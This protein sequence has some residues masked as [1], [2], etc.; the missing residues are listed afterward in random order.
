MAIS[1]SSEDLLQCFSCLSARAVSLYPLSL[2]LLSFAWVLELTVVRFH[3]TSKLNQSDTMVNSWIDCAEFH[4]L[5]VLFILPDQVKGCKINRTFKSYPPKNDQVRKA[6]SSVVKIL[7]TKLICGA[8]PVQNQL[9]SPIRPSPI[10]PPFLN[11]PFAVL[12]KTHAL[13]SLLRS[14][15]RQE[16]CKSNPHITPSYASHI[17]G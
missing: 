6:E 8:F 1:F 12:K 17:L 9:S 5:F 16:I 10:D 2:L 11:N 13:P 15:L 7:I 4:L 14:C 3:V